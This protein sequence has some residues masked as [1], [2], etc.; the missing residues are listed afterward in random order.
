MWHVPCCGMLG[1]VAGSGL[2]HVPGFG[3]LLAVALCWI[4]PL[5]GCGMFWDVAFSRMRHGPASA[6][7]LD[8][9]PAATKEIL[10]Y[11][12]Y[13]HSVERSVEDCAEYRENLN[14]GKCE[15]QEREIPGHRGDILY[16]GEGTRMRVYHAPY[17]CV[18]P[19]CDCSVLRRYEYDS[20]Q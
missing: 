16:V 6:M 2:W 4:W 13:F 9:A 20:S 18:R 5:L 1:D 19:Q 11:F 17:T 15:I 14:P 10:I 3:L 7:S 12:H 8:V